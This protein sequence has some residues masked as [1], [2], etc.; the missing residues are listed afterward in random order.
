MIFEVVILYRG[1]WSQVRRFGERREEGE[2]GIK[3]G[4]LCYGC[5]GGIVMN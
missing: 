5:Y 1:G 4:A 2:K 3:G